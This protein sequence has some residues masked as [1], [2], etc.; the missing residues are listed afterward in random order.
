MVCRPPSNGCAR[1]ACSLNRFP[2]GISSRSRG[3][4]T[5]DAAWTKGAILGGNG[6]KDHVSHQ[7]LT[8]YRGAVREFERRIV[9][10]VIATGQAVKFKQAF[11]YGG[12]LRLFHL[13]SRQ[14][15]RGQSL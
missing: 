7:N 13:E 10:H 4:A 15:Y 3:K 11:N 2:S 1:R 9:V 5:D 6:G 8:S 14:I 12:L